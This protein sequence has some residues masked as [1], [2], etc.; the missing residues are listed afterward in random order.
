MAAP[1]TQM[2][3]AN[4]KTLQLE[5]MTEPQRRQLGQNRKDIDK[6]RAERQK[7]ETVVRTPA[8]TVP[9]EPTT[10]KAKLP[11]SPIVSKT[12]A[13]LGAD[14]APP[15]NHA[16]PKPASKPVAKSE[17]KQEAKPVVKA[18][19]KAPVKAEAKSAP[20]AEPRSAAKPAPKAEPKPE[21][22][23]A[24]K[25]EPKPQPKP[26]PGGAPKPNPKS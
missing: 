16:T 13:E 23:P 12:P 7:V 14:G 5:P 10:T 21:A 20:K 25:A 17:P 3:G 1:L 11:A 4:Q 8:K 24:P 22:K 18:E 15:K 6:H 2:T 26:A 9:G 19:P